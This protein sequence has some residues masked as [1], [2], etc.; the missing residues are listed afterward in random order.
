[1]GKK[2]LSGLVVLL[3]ISVVRA[4][5]TVKVPAVKEI[6]ESAYLD[7]GRSGYFRTSFENIDVKGQKL[8]RSRQLLDLTVKRQ[9]V[10][11]NLRMQTGTDETPEG[12]VVGVFTQIDRSDLGPL[13]ITG[14]VKEMETERGKV[15][16]LH[17]DID[18][19]RIVRDD[20]WNDKVNGLQG[21]ENFFRGKTIKPGETY[22]YQ[23]YEPSLT[24]VITIRATVHEEE[25][26]DLA[27]AKKR[28]FRVILAPD[29][30]EAKNMSIQLPPL[31]VWM[32]KEGHIL[33]RLVEMP[34]LGKFVLVRTTKAAAL[35]AL[36]QHQLIDVAFKNMIFVNK[37]IH[38]ANVTASAV[39]RITIDDPHPETVLA[40]DARQ[41]VAK[42]DEKTIELSVKAIKN[43]PNSNKALEHADH[44][45]G[46]SFYLDSDNERI[47][48]IA[49]EVVGDE[50]NLW[51]KARRIEGWVHARM[52]IDGASPFV[53]ASKIAKEMKG[54]CRQCAM[55][56]AAMCRAAGVP[57]RTA[58]GFVYAESQG[59][60]FFATH[61]WTEVFVGGEWVGID[62]TLGEGA[63]GAAHIKVADHNWHDINSMVPLLPLQRAI[64]K[65]K[66]E[67][68]RFDYK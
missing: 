11:I 49:K 31:T 13:V 23:T 18:K 21:Q 7:G 4:Q 17:L 63:V 55:L 46:R 59:R 8:V 61:M 58:M 9:G 44:F 25:E 66:I 35:A 1:M 42:L 34:S 24:T 47:Q 16:I 5:E 6:W 64:G 65:T 38:R 45:L 60:S 12:K 56:T 67:I 62:A 57:S 36:N 68:I 33:R 37:R 10:S 29:K 30:V 39:Y 14:T 19:G 50:D 32:D 15:E 40:V 52:K 2:I 41:K 27:G 3:C 53:P 20:R 22:T 51:F 48:E 54:D 28:L 43:P 26:V